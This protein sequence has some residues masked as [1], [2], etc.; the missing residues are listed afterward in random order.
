[1]FHSMQL[2]WPCL[3]FDVIPDKLGMQRTKVERNLFLYS[4]FQF[5]MTAYIAAGTQADTTDNNKIIIMKL[6]QL[7]RTKGDDDSG[8]HKPI[9][10]MF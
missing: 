3:S 9:F 1:M 8:K 6:T 4:C 10:L 2:E 7:V 5:P